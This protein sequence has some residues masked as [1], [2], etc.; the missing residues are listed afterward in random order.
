MTAWMQHWNT[1]YD[2]MAIPRGKDK[3][4]EI[5]RMLARRSQELLGRYRR[6]E[7]VGDSSPADHAGLDDPVGYSVGPG[8]PG[9]SPAS[10][11]TRSPK[12]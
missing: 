7:P 2:G 3:R 8:W 5:H 12:A 1:G 4:R 9:S 10:P 11:T 6:Q